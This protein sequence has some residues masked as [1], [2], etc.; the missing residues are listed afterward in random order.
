MSQRTHLEY[1]S[2]Q[3]SAAEMMYKI[4]VKGSGHVVCHSLTKN[5][6]A[7]ST[8]NCMRLLSTKNSLEVVE[9]NLSP[10]SVMAFTKDHLVTA[11]KNIQRLNLTNHEIENITYS[12]PLITALSVSDEYIAVHNTANRVIV[13]SGTEVHFTL[14]EWES[15]VTAMTL[16]KG[17]T[18][19]VAFETNEFLVF[20]LKTRTLHH[21][22]HKYGSKFP[23]NYLKE[24]NR[25]FGLRS[26]RKHQLLLNTWYSYTIIDLRSP[27]PKRSA[28]KLKRPKATWNSILADHPL[29]GE[30]QKPKEAQKYRHNF[31][32]N[33][34]IGPIL[35]I[36]VAGSWVFAVELL[37]EDVLENLAPPRQKK[38]YGN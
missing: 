32:I 1:W 31:G 15:W 14:P 33:K 8:N 13:Y 6:I 35:N 4:F 36:T 37:W 27:P 16:T 10:C 21:F 29:H 34:S 30:V 12:G 22:S 11:G 25:T 2:I 3:T 26:L 28:I 20:E 9:T 5:W 23:S 24:P 18:L 7:Y 19:T 38:M 17:S